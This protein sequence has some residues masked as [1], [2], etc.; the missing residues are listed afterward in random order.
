VAFTQTA[1]EARSTRTSWTQ[2]PRPLLQDADTDMPTVTTSAKVCQT[3]CYLDN[4][5]IPPRAPRP[6][7]PWAYTYAM[8]DQL[9][10]AYP[11]GHPED[12][13]TFVILQEQPRRGS[14]REWGEVAGVLANMIGGR[15]PLVTK[16]MTIINWIARLDRT[17]PMRVTEEV[18]LVAVLL[19]E[20]RCSRV[21][22]REGPSSSSQHLAA[23]WP[24][25]HQQ[26][27]LTTR[28]VALHRR[29]HPTLSLGRLAHS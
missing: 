6:K 1:T 8:F 29:L 27:P 10:Q 16:L 13:V 2:V 21:P 14:A 26:G 17:D 12:F 22:L 7:L 5:L 18:A 24:A 9:L 4:E 15:Q 23:Q 25:Q 3:G 28:A 20:R 11:E 19:R